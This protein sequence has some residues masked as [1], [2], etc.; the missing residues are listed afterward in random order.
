M[1]RQKHSYNHIKDNN[2][3]TQSKTAGYHYKQAKI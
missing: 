1:L 2:Y 3:A